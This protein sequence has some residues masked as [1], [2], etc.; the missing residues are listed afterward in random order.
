MAVLGAPDVIPHQDLNNPVY[1]D[2]DQFAWG[3]IPYA[4]EAPYSQAPKDFIGPTRVVGRIPDITKGTDPAY[5]AGVL[6][7]A[8]TWRSRSAAD[9]A[10]YLGISA[11][12]WQGST[13]MSLRNTFGSA[14]DLQ[15]SPPKRA[16]ATLVESMPSRFSLKRERRS[17][18]CVISA[19][20]WRYPVRLPRVHPIC[21]RETRSHGTLPAK[22]AGNT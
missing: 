19:V 16:F 3:D 21:G 15:L 10:S 8:S 13:S 6:K 5:L 17:A 2:G 20:A 7:T 1:E 11:D 14:T 18:F 4:C 9:Y 12:V 22:Q